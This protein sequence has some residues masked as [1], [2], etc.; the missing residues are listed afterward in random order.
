M[1]KQPIPPTISPHK[2]AI[3]GEP[4]SQSLNSGPGL[5]VRD[6]TQINNDIVKQHQL[7]QQHQF[8]M[9]HQQQQQQTSNEPTIMVIISN[10]TWNNLDNDIFLFFCSQ[11]LVNQ[12]NL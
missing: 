6:A 10:Y 7:H 8:Q 3:N 5:F 1:D 12:S 2:T 9:H 11:R 4:Q